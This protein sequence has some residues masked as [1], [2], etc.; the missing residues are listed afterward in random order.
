VTAIRLFGA[1]SK[2]G[3]AIA[4]ATFILDQLTK[5]WLLH[6]EGV[7]EG[8]LVPVTPFF[9][10]TLLWNTGVSYSLWQQGAQWPL[11]AFSLI[12][13]AVL[14]NWLAATARRVTAMALGLIMGG[15]LGNALDRAIHGGVVDF[16]HLHWGR[17][18]WYVFN[19]AD[20][21][22]V[23]GVALL[24]YEGMAERGDRRGLGNA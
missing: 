22:I 21:A 15:A 1:W 3:L 5:Y 4:T 20:A 18:D 10:L 12:V 8:Q 7:S 19:L 14:L 11:I 13:C 16:I 2:V 23:A 9:N 24:L 6:V 17:F